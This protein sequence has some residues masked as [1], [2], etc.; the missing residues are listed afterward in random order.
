MRYAKKDDKTFSLWLNSFSYLHC[1]FSNSDNKNKY[2]VFLIGYVFISSIRIM[3][4]NYDKIKDEGRPAGSL[5]MTE[6]S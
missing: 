2:N 4:K 3:I 6:T 5:S 1:K